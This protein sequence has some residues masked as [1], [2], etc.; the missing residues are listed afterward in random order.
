MLGVS[1]VYLSRILFLLVVAFKFLINQSIAE[2]QKP[3]TILISIDGFK[4][5]YLSRGITP[6]LS[7]LAKEGAFAKGLLSVTPTVTF[8]NHVSIVTGEYPD[9]HGIVNNV[10]S[11]PTIPN[12]RFRLS[13]R[14]VLSNPIWWS[15]TKPI[16][17]S[18]IKQNKIVSTLFWPG[19]E[20]V[21]DGI[22]PQD[23]LPYKNISSKERVDTLLTW[24]NRP[25]ETRADFAT[26]YFSEV[27]SSGHMTG[28]QSAE[29][30]S[31]IQTVDAEIGRFIEGLQRLNL[32][33]STNIVIVSDHG[34]ADTDLEKIIFL[35]NLFPN[36][37]AGKFVWSGAFAG[38][39]IA[40]V[41]VDSVLSQ[42]SQNKN[43]DCWDK[44]KIPADYHF[45]TH[46]RIP[47]IFC[48]AQTGWTI[49]AKPG[50]EIIKGQHGY[51]SNEPDMWGIFI[52]FGPQ[53]K[54]KKL[55]FFENI[56]VY[57][58]LCK[59]I[60]IYPENT[61]ANPHLIGELYLSK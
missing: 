57:L 49:L 8:P 11:D 44:S 26:L 4:P 46:R 14:A 31:A 30:H 48:I 35:S 19:T 50:D 16:W 17:V 51:K 33:D 55:D 18:A 20:V 42:L 5:E 28:T 43:M 52:A 15:E 6:N 3:L 36:L 7:K 29:T 27:D 37:P 9:K 23:W 45:G 22:Q 1:T 59:L 10:M 38:L 24:L 60:N 54:S 61:S 39:D 21:I 41:E 34:M 53:I 2:P 47:Q 32:M 40:P 13:D 58:L 25:N 56:D 12:A